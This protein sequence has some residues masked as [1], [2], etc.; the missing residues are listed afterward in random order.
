MG[1]RAFGLLETEG[2]PELEGGFTAGDLM[3]AGD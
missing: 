3:V 2:G 1:T